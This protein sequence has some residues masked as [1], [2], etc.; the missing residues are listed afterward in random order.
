MLGEHEE[1]MR[2]VRPVLPLTLVSVCIDYL[3]MEEQTQSYRAFLFSHHCFA[4]CVLGMTFDILSNH[5]EAANQPWSRKWIKNQV[6][7]WSGGNKNIHPV[8]PLLYTSTRQEEISR[9]V[10]KRN[11]CNTIQHNIWKQHQRCLCWNHCSSSI[12][13]QTDLQSLCVSVSSLS[14]GWAA[15]L[16]RSTSAGGSVCSVALHCLSIT[17]WVWITS[18]DEII[19]S[20]AAITAFARGSSEPCFI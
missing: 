19:K 15:S 14:D 9:C 10:N 12:Q 20:D 3:E 17:T 2:T 18:E 8:N 1:V 11:V 7:F 4:I 5:Q 6:K 16:G 13:W